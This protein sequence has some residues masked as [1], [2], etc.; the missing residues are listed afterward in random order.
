[1]RV[2]DKELHCSS[3][4]D[5]FVFTA[6]EQEL[7]L[8]RGV[9]RQPRECPPCKRGTGAKRPALTVRG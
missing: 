3:C 9:Q 2:T 6:G 5:E 8:L 1:M 4:G 7:N